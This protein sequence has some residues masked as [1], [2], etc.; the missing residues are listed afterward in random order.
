MAPYPHK[1]IQICI[2]CRKSFTPN[3]LMS[4]Y[5]KKHPKN[6]IPCLLCCNLFEF[7]IDR[8]EHM[9]AVYR[10]IEMPPNCKKDPRKNGLNDRKL[11]YEWESDVDANVLD[12]EIF[13]SPVEFTLIRTPAALPSDVLGSVD[14]IFTSPVEFTLIRTLDDLP[15]DA[16]G[17]LMLRKEER[18]REREEEEKKGKKNWF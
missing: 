8:D 1:R 2:F 13:T 16:L 11:I 4:H 12:D 18:E 5:E 3:G 10:E 7:Q 9:L 6:K 15:S 17:S 14:A